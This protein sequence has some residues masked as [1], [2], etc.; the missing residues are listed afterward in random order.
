MA[1]EMRGE[2]KKK[3]SD[4]RLGTCFGRNGTAGLNYNEFKKSICGV[5]VK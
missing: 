1:R 4:T 2:V 3:I 5:I